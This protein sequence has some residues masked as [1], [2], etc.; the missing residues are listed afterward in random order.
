[1]CSRGRC[2]CKEHSD[3]FCTPEA[4]RHFSSYVE[5]EQDLNLLEILSSKDEN[6]EE[7]E[8]GSSKIDDDS[9]PAPMTL[10]VKPSLTTWAI[11]DMERRK[12]RQG[13]DT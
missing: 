10:S 13:R 4:C 8:N 2:E 12:K 1:M 5:I 6:E 11:K 3:R 9:I 7:D